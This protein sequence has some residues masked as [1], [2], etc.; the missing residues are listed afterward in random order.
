MPFIIARVNVPVSK[1]QETEIKNR[2]GRAIELVPGKSEQW[3]MCLFDENMPAYF[4]G[5]NDDPVAYVTVEVFSRSAVSR[6]VWEQL[7]SVI[8]Q[9]LE[10]ELG[11]SPSRTEAGDSGPVCFHRIVPSGPTRNVSGTP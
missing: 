8:C 11:I 10:Q 4:G 5:S 6:S 2:M 7:T 9:A 1:E 3:L